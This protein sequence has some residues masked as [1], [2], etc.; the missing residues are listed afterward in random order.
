MRDIGFTLSLR[1][2]ILLFGAMFFG[3]A[4]LLGATAVGIG[5][6]EANATEAFSRQTRQQCGACH[7][8]PSGSGKLTA[9][10][11]KFKANGFRL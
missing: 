10:G 8:N 9:K 11:Q 5:S 2:R 7:V 3:I 6:R 1:P 4:I